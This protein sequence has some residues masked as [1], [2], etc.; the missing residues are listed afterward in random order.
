MAESFLS[1]IA[2]TLFNHIISPAIKETISLRN[3]SDLRRL[4]EN[5]TYIKSALFDAEKLQQH[6]QTLRLSLTKL[7]G[8]F[9]DAEDVLD[10]FRC[11]AL[12]KELKTVRFSSISIPFAYSLRMGQKIKKI[13]ERL[14]TIATDFKRFNLGENVQILQNPPY[15]VQSHR[16]THS[17][18]TFK[19]LGRDQDKE[20]IIR[21]VVQ[22]RD[23]QNI[24]VIPIVGIGGLGKTT[25]AQFVYNDERITQCFPL[26]LWV[27]VSEFFDVARL[28]CEIIYCIN[29]ERCDGLP[30]N[31]L[32]TLLQSLIKGQKFL[33]VMDDVWNEDIVKWNELRNILM[34][35]DDLHQSKIIVTTRSLAV[36][37]VMGT[38]IPY[39]L[40]A[41]NHQDSL[42]LLLK[43]AFKEGDEVRYPNLLGIADEIVKKCR[44]IPLAVRTMG[45]LLYGK[46]D[47]HDWVLIRDNHI[48]KLDEQENGILPVLKLSYNHL[49]PH[50]KRCLTYLSLFPK[51]TV[52]DT[53]YII[54]FWM[55]H[56]LLKSPK[57]DNDECGEHI[58]LQYFKDLWS[59]G[60]LQDVID[61][62]SYYRFKMHDLIHDLALNVSQEECLIIYQQTISASENVRHLTFAGR[63][64]LRTPQSF[65]KK[66]KG[67]RTLIFLP[68]SE[69]LRVIEKSFL[70]ACILYF[71]YLR[72]LELENNLSRLPKPIHKLQS[73]LTLRLLGVSKLQVPDKLQRLINL[74]LLEITAADIQLREIQ[75]G[76]QY[77]SS[78]RYLVINGCNELESLPRSLKHLPK[79]EEIRIFACRNSWNP[80]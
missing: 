31:A 58:G 33:L 68:P 7:R 9:Y 52:Y 1:I 66:L 56:G 65:L 71:K 25:V 62:F 72:L 48:W 23:G 46:T 47:Q 61:Y 69:G 77:L 60:F 3:A 26:K 18:M 21:L 8:V 35:L 42:S 53:D 15:V 43:W 17:F 41:L 24:P 75:P 11:D 13:N 40:K 39:E 38:H 30:V 2:E 57:Q 74:R 63:N 80:K 70:T 50:L 10:E 78:L 27:C 32:L 54:Q 67:M 28:L 51:D 73:L 55:A 79:L 36:V 64:P 5:M 59:R 6:N 16:D 37:S 22:P 45:S 44:G 29:R 12:R 76:M 20:N 14:E 49:P 4:E 19:V 34:K